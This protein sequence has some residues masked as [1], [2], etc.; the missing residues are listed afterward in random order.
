MEKRWRGPRRGGPMTLE[1]AGATG[2]T[3]LPHSSLSS[4]PGPRPRPR[5]QHSSFGEELEIAVAPRLSD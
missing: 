4:R 5:R 2:A 3:P 1:K